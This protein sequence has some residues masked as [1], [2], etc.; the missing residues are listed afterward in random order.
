MMK[1]TKFTKAVCIFLCLF[2]VLTQ[3]SILTV[4][5]DSGTDSE[6]NIEY[7]I[8]NGLITGS[9]VN[10][11]KLADYYYNE[12]GYRIKKVCSERIEEYNYDEHGSLSSVIIT[13]GNNRYELEYNYNYSDNIPILEHILYAG[14]TYS[15]LRDS[16]NNI[17]GLLNEENIQVVRYVYEGAVL[18]NVFEVTEYGDVINHNQDFVGNLNGICW[19]DAY[20]DYESGLYY[21]YR[22]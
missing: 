3:V 19:Q 21:K 7:T 20:Y 2:I 18:E 16:T 13:I 11:N 12:S 8:E 14:S 15:I 4:K 22:R 10:N 1:Q 6:D 17:I 9:Y 5:A